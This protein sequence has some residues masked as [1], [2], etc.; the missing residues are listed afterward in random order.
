M[1]FIR[2]AITG[3]AATAVHY[4][5]LIFLVEVLHLQPAIPAAIGALCGALVAYVGNHKFTFNSSASHGVALPRFMLIAAMGA[6]LNGLIVW[7]ATAFLGWHYII[8][9]LLATLLVLLITYQINRSWT[10]Q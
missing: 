6:A 3:G 1:A 4:S 2:Y 9:Q 5:I 10:F 7:T 8:G